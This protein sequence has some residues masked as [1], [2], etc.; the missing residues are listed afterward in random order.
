MLFTSFPFGGPTIS[1]NPRSQTGEPSLSA[2]Q[3]SSSTAIPRIPPPCTPPPRPP[4]PKTSLPNLRPKII[5]SPVP[6]PAGVCDLS[7][8]NHPAE[9]R[10]FSADVF[11]SLPGHVEPGITVCNATWLTPPLAIRSSATSPSST[12][13]ASAPIF[14]PSVQ[15]E[16]RTISS[17]ATHQVHLLTPEPQ[18][19]ASCSIAGSSSASSSSSNSTSKPEKTVIVQSLIETPLLEPPLFAL[20]PRQLWLLRHRRVLWMMATIVFVLVAA[21]AIAGGVI[22]KMTTVSSSDLLL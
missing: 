11:A 15:V 9:H 18:N 14:D 12:N 16:T 7:L 6:V 5:L 21:T 19:W 3:G 17:T 8:P 22:W 4:R 1:I 13:F 2:R 20:T 10:T